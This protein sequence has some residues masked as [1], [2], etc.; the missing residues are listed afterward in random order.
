MAD[1]NNGKPPWH[2]RRK[3]IIT[4]LLF[5][6]F[7]IFYIMIWGTDS[8]VHEAIVLGSFATASAVIGTYVFGATWSDAQPSPPE[9]MDG[10]YE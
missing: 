10:D 6:A 4:T 3:I 1:R 2:L 7:C 9:N 5:C 8:G